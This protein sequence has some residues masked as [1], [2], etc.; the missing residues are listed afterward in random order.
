MKNAYTKERWAKNSR[1]AALGSSLAEQA[2]KGSMN[3]GR[4]VSS[5]VD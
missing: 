5:L 3:F 4:K 1:K 2:L